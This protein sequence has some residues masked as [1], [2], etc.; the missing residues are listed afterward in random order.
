MNAVKKRGTMR[1]VRIDGGNE[2]SC[3][4]HPCHSFIAIVG[5]TYC[6][7]LGVVS[8]ERA[9]R[10]QKKDE[11]PGGV[12]AGAADGEVHSAGGRVRGRRRSTR[13]RGGALNGLLVR[14]A[15]GEGE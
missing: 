2:A 15:Q 1:V 13:A 5:K 4:T 7:C 9:G 6:G 3:A 12:A 10:H 11:R 14:G 8:A